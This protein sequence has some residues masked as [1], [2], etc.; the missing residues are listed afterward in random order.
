[1]SMTNNNSIL[2]PKISSDFV[3]G[4]LLFTSSIFYVQSFQ[5]Y[6]W[7][8]PFLPNYMFRKE[9]LRR[10]T[11]S[12]TPTKD[13]S[14]ELISRSTK[15]KLPA[16]WKKSYSIDMSCDGDSECEI[17]VIN[18][19]EES[20]LFCWVDHAGCLHHFYVINDRSIPDKSVSNIHKEYAQAGHAFICLRKL[21]SH[22]R[23]LS[24][25]P[26]DA[27]LFHFKPLKEKMKYSVQ[28]I[29]ERKRKW[30]FE[31]QAVSVLV[32]SSQLETEEIIDT[33]AKE[34]DDFVIHG[35]QV[36]CERELFALVPEVHAALVEDLSMAVDLLPAQ[37]C[38]KLQMSTPFYV[39]KELIYGPKASPIIG[40]S[41]CFH[42][43]GGR[44]WLVKHGLSVSKEGCIEIASAE[45]YLICRSLWGP[46]GV[47]LHELSHAYHNKFCSDGYDNQEVIQAYELAMSK[48]LYHSVPVH[49]KQGLNGPVKGYACTNC[50]EFFAELSVGYHYDKADSLEFNKWFPF[51]REQLKEYD[52]PSFLLL[53]K[54]WHQH[55][56]DGNN[57]K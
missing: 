1:M 39:N 11:P 13:S 2:L 56:K 7:I 31:K 50:L 55:E 32:T 30:L 3:I 37:A 6:Y 40:D 45:N 28:L 44:N 8:H 14:Y 20:V 4:L 12:P 19:L 15:S 22:P 18:A 26:E 41:M 53:E 16:F 17:E 38:C 46:G 34:Y 36:K 35:F 27:L 23:K 43:I 29:N 54:L 24:D 5:S 47:L 52:L 49:G 48:G 10:S 51:N 9:L 33:S 42:P 25:V 57:G 21:N